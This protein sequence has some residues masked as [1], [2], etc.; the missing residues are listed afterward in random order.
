MVKPTSRLDWRKKVMCKK[1]TLLIPKM[2]L[3]LR[4]WEVLEFRRENKIEN[5]GNDAKPNWK[6]II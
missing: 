4:F 6:P 5:R 2:D 3:T 1:Y